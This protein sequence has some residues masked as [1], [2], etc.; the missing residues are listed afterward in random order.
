MRQVDLIYPQNFL[1]VPCKKV[2]WHHLQIYTLS[3]LLAQ[4]LFSELHIQSAGDVVGALL[5]REERTI[6]YFKNGQF[7]GIAFSNIS[8]PYLFP[9]V[10]LLNIFCFVA[11]VCCEWHV[12]IIPKHMSSISLDLQLEEKSFLTSRDKGSSFSSRCCDLFE[13][14]CNNFS[15]SHCMTEFIVKKMKP[16]IVYSCQC[17]LLLDQVITV[18]R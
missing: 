18:S 8:E 15:I 3:Q 7:L 11:F 10:C 17:H 2:S 1:E 14:H 5:D 16:K 4:I 6:S 13:M 9:T 12:L